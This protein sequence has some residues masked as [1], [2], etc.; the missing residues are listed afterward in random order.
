[1]HFS[2][3][4]QTPGCNFQTAK[5]AVERIVIGLK[6]REIDVFLPTANEADM[7]EVI[8]PFETLIKAG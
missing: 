8:A 5:N 4:L 3:T 1:M 7:R 6:K 2:N